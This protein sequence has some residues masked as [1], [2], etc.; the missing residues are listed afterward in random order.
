MGTEHRER[1]NELTLPNTPSGQSAFV[2]YPILFP[3]IYQGLIFS[4]EDSATECSYMTSNMFTL[5]I[6]LCSF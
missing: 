3:L 6:Y 1:T 2:V 5:S 4:K